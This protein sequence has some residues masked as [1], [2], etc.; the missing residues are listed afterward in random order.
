MKELI[1]EY[2]EYLELKGKSPLT[3]RDY[4][5]HLYIFSDFV[6]DDMSAL[7][8]EEIDKFHS[9]LAGSGISLNTQALYLITIRTFLK[10]LRVKKGLNVPDPQA[11][12]L[13]KTRRKI[14]DALSDK[15][16]KELLKQAPM[17]D[18][19]HIRARAILVFLLGSGIR[20][21]ELCNL[22][23]SEIDTKEKWFRVVGKGDKQRVCFMTEEMIRTL[24]KYLATRSNNSS[25]LF[26]Q[27]D[28]GRYNADQPITT[29]SIE[30]LVKEYGVRAGIL[31]KVTPHVLRRTFAVRLLR[32][33]V[34]LRYIQEFLGHESIQTTTLYTFIE[35]TDLERI[36][37]LANKKVVKDVKKD[38]EQ[39]V[40]SR[41]SFNKLSG[42]VGKTMERQN[43]ILEKLDKKGKEEIEETPYIYEEALK[44]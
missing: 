34:D 17:L 44:N 3:V 22:K 18:P 36:F 1:N 12:E 7:T 11:I 29:R 4:K 6:K 40:L 27:Y 42:M 43:R 20:V 35:R 38:N 2:L 41:E 26:T 10:F 19:Y 14:Q 15:D 13:P 31:K 16:V 28:S 32:K 9:R 25:Y 39:I 23:V 30:R 37:H 8:I 24:R 5:S 21:Q 33:G